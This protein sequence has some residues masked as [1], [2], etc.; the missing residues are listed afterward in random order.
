MSFYFL[1][2]DIL[3]MYLQL[4]VQLIKFL[5]GAPLQSLVNCDSD[6]FGSFVQICQFGAAN[7]SEEGT[8]VICMLIF[9]LVMA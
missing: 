8:E 9:M 2:V 5:F 3:Y 7:G 4:R 1:F 6:R